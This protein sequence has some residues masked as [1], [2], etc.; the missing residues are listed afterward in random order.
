[1]AK[2]TRIQAGQYAV[3]DGGFIVKKIQDG[4]LLTTTWRYKVV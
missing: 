2:V 1:M 4:L 3:D